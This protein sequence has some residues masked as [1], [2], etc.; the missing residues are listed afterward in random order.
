[1]RYATRELRQVHTQI[2][3]LADEL[4]RRTIERQLAKSDIEL[5]LE[6]ML[7]LQHS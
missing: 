3:E 5:G 7:G 2:V 1:M 4:G 6:H